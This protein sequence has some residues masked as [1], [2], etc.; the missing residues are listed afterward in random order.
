MQRTQG[1]E[2]QLVTVSGSYNPLIPIA[3]KGWVRLRILN[4]SVSKF[5]RLRLEDHPLTI[6]ATDG[7]LLPGPI[8][9][10]ELLVVPGQRYDIFVRGRTPGGSFRFLNLPYSRFGAMTGGMGVTSTNRTETL[11]TLEYGGLTDRTWSL[12]ERL[13]D[14]TLNAAP[15]VTRSFTFGMG[16]GMFGGGFT[17]NGR[18]F[19]PGSSRHEGRA[20]FRRRLGLNQSVHDGPS[21]P[22]THERISGCRIGR[23]R[24]RRLA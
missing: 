12:P 17:I 16:M 15:S 23:S 9:V 2:G 22:S 3:A 5:Y 13:A 6:V 4:A 7:G 24:R 14:T 21:F 1:R 18:Q 10:D 20:R 8:E 11:A 19:D